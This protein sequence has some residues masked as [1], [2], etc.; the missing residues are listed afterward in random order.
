MTI[1]GM[2]AAMQPRN[3]PRE[4]RAPALLRVATL[5]PFGLALAIQLLAG[6][7]LSR[8]MFQQ[9]AVA[10]IP[11]GLVVGGLVLAWAALG[12]LVVWTTGSRAVATLAYVFIT[13]PSMFAVVL[14]PAILLIIQK[15]P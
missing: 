7:T 5:M 9:P 4:W 15:L 10:G 12:A 6:P 2:P 14:G 8:P 11:L 1:E 3:P 13:L